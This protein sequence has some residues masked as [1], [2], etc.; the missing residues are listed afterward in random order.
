MAEK[1]GITWARSTFNPWIGCTKIGP[2]CDHC[3]AEALDAR[4]VFQ[5]VVHFGSGVPRMRTSQSNWNQVR[6]W[7][8]KAAEE[9]AAGMLWH[10]RPGFW[11][12]FCASLADVFDNEVAQKWRDDLWNLIA[13]TPNLSWLLVTKRIGN[14]PKMVAP[15]WI[16]HGFPDNVRLLITV[17]NQ[18][19]A[20]RDIHKLLALN[21]KN[22]IS[23]EPALGPVD[24]RPWLPYNP[25]NEI[26]ASRGSRLQGRPIGRVG[27]RHDGPGLAGGGTAL[28]SMEKNGGVDPMQAPSRGERHRGIS[29]GARD[30]E[31]QE[32]SRARAST[33]MEAL[34]G[35]DHRSVDRQ[36]QGRQEE[37]ERAEQPRTSDARGANG[38]RDQN[39]GQRPDEK[40][41]TISWVIVGGESA[42]RGHQARPFDIDWARNT[43]EQCRAD[44]V[45]VFVKQLGSH[46]AWTGH[47]NAEEHWPDFTPPEHTDT[48]NGYWRCVLKDRAG[49]DLAEWPEDLRLQQFPL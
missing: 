35:S 10:G 22:G 46:V 20:N 25:V 42:Q 40:S 1:T 31:R 47:Q 18:E 13:A 4:K 28:E 30:G 3:Y 17:V 8:R 37:A 32:D 7:D 48:G 27:D 43:I 26:E 38:P 33:G 16:E 19:E 49:G 6:K 2:G 11:P 12:V 15:L 23:Y 24:F 41:P 34:Q 21:C 29:T 45:P 36:P 5:G 9:R 44:Y 39:V 14:V